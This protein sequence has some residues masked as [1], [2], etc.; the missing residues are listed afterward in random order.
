[1]TLSVN[2]AAYAVSPAYDLPHLGPR[3]IN[4]RTG[5]LITGAVGIA[6]TPWNLIANPHVYSFTW[7][8]VGGPLGTVAGSHVGCWVR[9]RLL[10]VGVRH[11]PCG[12]G[13]QR[14]ARVLTF[15]S[16][17]LRV[18]ALEA[19]PH[20]EKHVSSFRF[21]HCVVRRQAQLHLVRR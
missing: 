12:P 14:S 17:L 18:R 13:E 3:F 19:I 1:M 2:I 6:I 5:A 15:C 11:R 8:G 4:F 7:L 16:S 9:W 20:D 21:E 10:R